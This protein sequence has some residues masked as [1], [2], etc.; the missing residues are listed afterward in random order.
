MNKRISPFSNGSQYGDWTL[1]NCDKCRKSRVVNKISPCDIELELFRAYLEYGTVPKE[2][3]K[4]M[5]YF[6]NEGA[7]SWDCP[8]LL[9]EP[10]E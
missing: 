4:R 9:G 8:E 5:G 10:D 3:A 6:G 7:H 1:N 2:M